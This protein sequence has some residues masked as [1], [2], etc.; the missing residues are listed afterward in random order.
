MEF[1]IYNYFIFYVLIIFSVVGYGLLF[2]H[3]TNTNNT[4]NNFGYLGLLGLFCLT[5]YSYFSN[6]FLAHSLVHNSVLILFGILSY[7]YFITKNT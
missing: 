1:N 3:I 7:L 6:L 5:I 4:F 2:S